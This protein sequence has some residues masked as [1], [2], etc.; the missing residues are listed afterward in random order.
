LRSRPLG[1][2]LSAPRVVRTALLAARDEACADLQRGPRRRGGLLK[3]GLGLRGARG[4]IGDGRAGPLQAFVLGIHPGRLL[5]LGQQPRLQQS[6][7][8][9][10]VTPQRLDGLLA[11][12]VGQQRLDLSVA[13]VAE[14]PL[15]LRAEH[16][17]EECV[18]TAAQPFDAARVGL[19][20][21]V[22]DRAVLK[23]DGPR[24]T[25]SLA[26]SNRKASVRRRPLSRITTCERKRRPCSAHTSSFV[27]SGRNTWS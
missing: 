5:A 9:G 27:L 4:R 14:L 1:L 23:F 17:G 3:R 6:G 10:G 12:Q 13:V 8:L 16:R 2:Q 11:E 15:T 20:L 26:I 18:C 19:D 24:R 21:A 7:R 22:R 25:P